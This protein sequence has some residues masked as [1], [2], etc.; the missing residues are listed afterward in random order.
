M[1]IEL[2]Q[3]HINRDSYAST[4]SVIRALAER[5]LQPRL[6]AFNASERRLHATVTQEKQDYRVT[7]RLHLPPKK[8]LVAHA[9]NE[10]LRSAL[11]EA[12]EELGRQAERHHAHISS[13]ELAK[14]KRRQRKIKQLE[15]TV[16]DLAATIQPS[17][18]T[19]SALLPRLE[20]WLRHEMTYLRANGDLQENYPRI[21]DIRDEVFLQLQQQWNELDHSEEALYLKMLK[22]A[23]E[24]LQKEVADNKMHEGDFSLDDE[25]P[26]DASEQ[27]EE[28]V[29]EAY[30]EFY[31][32]DDILHVEDLIPAS[33]SEETEPAQEHLA[34]SQCYRLMGLLPMGWRQVFVLVHRE[35]LSPEQIAGSILQTEVQEVEAMLKMAEDFIGAHLAE[36]GLN[37]SINFPG[38]FD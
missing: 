29:G 10:N 11:Q 8:I 31:Q 27:A 23:Q 9:E 20:S 21:A 1:K 37:I 32:P 3:R 4:L 15:S 28:M 6:R 19:L 18:V 5:H 22:T 30:G 34:V 7:L 12:I 14:R 33:V 38:L 17:E 26:E 36:Q 35:S 25:V 16:A 13:R 24:I 2:T